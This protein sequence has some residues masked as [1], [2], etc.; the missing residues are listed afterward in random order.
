MDSIYDDGYVGFNEKDEEHE[1]YE[2]GPLVLN[3]RSSVFD[4]IRD[5]VKKKYSHTISDADYAIKLLALNEDGTYRVNSLWADKRKKI[6]H[7]RDMNARDFPFVMKQYRTVMFIDRTYLRQ[8]EYEIDGDI[9]PDIYTDANDE[10]YWKFMFR[11]GKVIKRKR[12]NSNT[13]NHRDKH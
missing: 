1:N 11:L 12:K 2:D 7:Y 4:N 9:E 13:E 8:M 5:G 10:S 6:Y 3:I